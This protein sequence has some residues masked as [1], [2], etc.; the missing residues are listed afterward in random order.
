MVSITI[1]MLH[2]PSLNEWS[3]SGPIKLNY[4]TLL[5]TFQ[6]LTTSLFRTTFHVLPS[7]ARKS[8]ASDASTLQF[9]RFLPNKVTRMKCLSPISS[10]PSKLGNLLY[11]LMSSKSNKLQHNLLQMLHITMIS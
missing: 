5:N 10:S 8:T 9:F 11:V 6:K 4:C 2:F 7:A 3:S 1:S